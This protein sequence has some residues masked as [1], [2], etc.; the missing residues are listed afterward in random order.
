MLKN[1]ENHQN[2]NKKN[3]QN[4]KQ[5]FCNLT[6]NFEIYSGSIELGQVPTYR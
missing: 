2:M 6:A 4:S 5:N 3:Y 1:Q